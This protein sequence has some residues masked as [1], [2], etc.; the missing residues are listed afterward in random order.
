MK[1][2]TIEDRHK[3]LIDGK[4]YLEFEVD[5]TKYKAEC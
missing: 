3:K 4:L 1:E 2:L 5:N